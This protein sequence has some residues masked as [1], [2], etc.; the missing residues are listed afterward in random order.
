MRKSRRILS[1]F[2]QHSFADFFFILLLSDVTIHEF[3][4]SIEYI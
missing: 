2:K 3:I 4:F 1:K